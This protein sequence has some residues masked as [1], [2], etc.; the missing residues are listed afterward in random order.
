VTI[1]AGSVCRRRILGCK[2][3]PLGRV[4]VPSV[5]KRTQ[6]SAKEERHLGGVSLNR[7][8]AKT[9]NEAQYVASLVES[10]RRCPVPADLK[11]SICKYGYG[12]SS[13]KNRNGWLLF[14]SS[15]TAEGQNL[16]G[17]SVETCSCLVGNRLA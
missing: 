16:E 4:A 7:R 12:S 8:T 3:S 15:C 6:S 11:R 10:H 14:A 2:P 1:M 9:G 5:P 17:M 13:A